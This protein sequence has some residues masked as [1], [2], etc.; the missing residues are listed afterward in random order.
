VLIEFWKITRVMDVTVEKTAS[1]FPKLKFAHRGSYVDTDTKKF[2][3]E[4]TRYMSYALFPCV[5]GYFIYSL[6]Y[7]KHKSWCVLS[8]STFIE[9]SRPLHPIR[10]LC[11]VLRWPYLDGV[12]V[13]HTIPQPW[14]FKALSAL[15]K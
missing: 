7:E 12:S 8:P 11:F 3:D 1:G 10:F 14:H 4:A 6:V 15:C 9:S 2:D 13:A 5:V